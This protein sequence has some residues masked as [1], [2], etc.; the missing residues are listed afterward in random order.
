MSGAKLSNRTEV[1]IIFARSKETDW[2]ALVPP[3]ELMG[4]SNIL[5]ADDEESL[6]QHL[7]QTAPDVVIFDTGLP[8]NVF[9]LIDAIR[10]GRLGPNP[11]VTLMLF[12]ASPTAHEVTK[13]LGSGVDEVMVKP[14]TAS[15]VLQRFS[16]QATKRKPFCSTE[17]YIGPDRRMDGDKLLGVHYVPVH[18]PNTLKARLEGRPLR[19][20][21]LKNAI[22]RTQIQLAE[23]RIRRELRTL[24]KLAIGAEQLIADGYE[25]YAMWQMMDNLVAL[26]RKFAITCANAGMVS[27]LK[28]LVRLLDA[29]L[30][31]RD[32]APKLQQQ[33]LAELAPLAGAIDSALSPPAVMRSLISIP[34][35]L[36]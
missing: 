1:K 26:S 30:V 12:A 17:N 15:A 11:F 8:Y 2:Q 7:I 32:K 20:E 34:S 9:S 6:R 16:V 4:F 14:V 22:A 3:L 13:L 24:G 5:A 10:W 33:D 28:L 23:Q 31:A 36:S 29:A 21:E 18:A 19:G 25:Q 27:E 35:F